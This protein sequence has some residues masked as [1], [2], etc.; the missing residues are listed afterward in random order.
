MACL[1]MVALHWCVVIFCVCLSYIM[2]CVWFISDINLCIAYGIM[3]KSIHIKIFYIN[4]PED[5]SNPVLMKI[6]PMHKKYTLFKTVR[7]V[8]NKLCVDF[9]FTKGS[10]MARLF[11]VH[12]EAQGYSHFG[13]LGKANKYN[14]QMSPLFL[15][16]L[17]EQWK[18]TNHVYSCLSSPETVTQKELFIPSKQMP[19]LLYWTGAGFCNDNSPCSC[20][21][22][23]SLHLTCRVEHRIN[24]KYIKKLCRKDR[25]TDISEH[26]NRSL[27]TNS[28]Y[29]IYLDSWNI[30]Y[31]WVNLMFQWMTHT[32]RSYI[33]PLH[34]HWVYEGYVFQRIKQ[35][36]P[37]SACFLSIVY[38]WLFMVY[39]SFLY[40]L[41]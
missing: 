16:H 7:H 1:N 4:P 34:L 31:N 12:C 28:S 9:M 32:N 2:P 26:F 6:T 20:A 18:C 29:Y 27:S 10:W 39:L 40:A 21:V 30:S 24:T 36:A 23:P 37:G 8:A 15:L 33:S 3:P 25:P 14:Q 22:S 5:T 17:M 35:F 19:F 38:T 13:I 41:L 11:L